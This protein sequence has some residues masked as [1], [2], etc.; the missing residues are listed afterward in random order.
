M[1]LLIYYT[2]AHTQRNSF[3]I[4]FFKD[5]K[6]KLWGNLPKVVENTTVKSPRLKKKR[7]SVKLSVL[8]SSDDQDV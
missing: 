4:L 6:R 3:K 5:F 7:T 1:L 8:F 2:H